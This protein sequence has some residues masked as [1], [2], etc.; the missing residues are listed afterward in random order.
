[1]KALAAAC[2]ADP[3]DVIGNKHDLRPGGAEHQQIYLTEQL[4]N[5][6]TNC[7]QTLKGRDLFW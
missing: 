5:P 2:T 1:M 6:Q 3:T 7:A 4:I